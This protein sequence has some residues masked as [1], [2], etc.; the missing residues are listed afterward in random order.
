M[1]WKWKKKQLPKRKKEKRTQNKLKPLKWYTHEPPLFFSG[2]M[3]ILK[4]NDDEEDTRQNAI[5]IVIMYE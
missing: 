1:K 4:V 3:R 5:K 2:K